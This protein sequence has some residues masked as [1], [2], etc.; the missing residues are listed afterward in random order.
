LQQT[1]FTAGGDHDH[2][3]TRKLVM[4]KLLITTVVFGAFAAGSAFAAPAADLSGMSLSATGEFASGSVSA[5]DGASDT[6]KTSAV[7]LQARYDW[8]L[9]P[10][11][12]IGLGGSY[13]SGS[14]QHGSYASGNAASVNNRYSLDIIP[15]VALSNDFQLYGKLSSIYGNAASNDGVNS[16]D[17]QGVGYGLGVRQ[18]LDKNMFWQVGYDLNQFRDVTFSNGTTSSLQERV[19][20]I[21]VGYKF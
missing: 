12:A 16:S 7:G 2:P 4:K 19:L 21:G 17:V 18:M 3:F 9:A 6:G 13:T 11:F 10:N 1:S 20:S 14:H 8:A 5:A 15:T